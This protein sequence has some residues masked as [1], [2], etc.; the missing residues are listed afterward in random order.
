[1]ANIEGLYV[2]VPYCRRKCIYCDF[3]AAGVRQARWDAFVAALLGEMGRRRVELSSQSPYTIYIGGG[4]PSLMPGGHFRRLSAGLMAAMGSVPV[5]FTIEANPEDLTEANLECWRECGVDRLSVGVQTL[6][7]TLLTTLGRLH[8]AECAIDGVSMASRYFDNISVDLM[9]GLPGQSI[10][11]LLGD[12]EAMAALRPKH[13]SAYSLMYEE[14]TALTRLRDEHRMAECDDV[15]VVEMFLVMKD[16]LAMAGYR[17]YETSNYAM[18]GYESVHNTGY[19]LG[20]RY[21]GLGPAAH[22]YDGL[23]TRRWNPADIAAYLRHFAGNGAGSAF[24]DEEYLDD[25]ELRE[26]YVMTRLRLADGF[27]VDEFR[28]RFGEARADMLLAG[29]SRWERRGLLTVDDDM[30]GKRIS[31]TPHGVMVSDEIIADLM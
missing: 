20:R 28:H 22:S 25:D 13:I 19:W 9:F 23:R 1:M 16:T 5:E 17:R 4:T 8:D 31:L 6:D 10:Q 27:P 21:L 24:Y 15:D 14:R 12:V 11:R 2:H 26:E 29:A 7:N 30:G 18:P 3:Y